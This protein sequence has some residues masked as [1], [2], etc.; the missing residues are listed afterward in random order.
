MILVSDKIDFSKADEDDS[1]FI[2]SSTQSYLDYT[3]REGY[4]SN[5]FSIH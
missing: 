5:I 3:F 4:F 2:F 1:Y